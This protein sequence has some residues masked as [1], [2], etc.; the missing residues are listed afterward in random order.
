MLEMIAEPVHSNSSH[1]GNSIPG[2]MQIS[3]QEIQNRKEL[4]G[5]TKEDEQNLSE[6]RLVMVDHIDP[7]ITEY[8]DQLLLSEEV[9]QLIDDAETLQRVCE[10]M[11]RYIIDL[12]EGSYDLDYVN[13]RLR[14]GKVHH[15]IGVQPK[16]YVSAVV[17]L[18]KLLTEA[19]LKNVPSDKNAD[20]LRSALTK[21]FMFDMQ[22]VF[23]S[24]VSSL[25]AEEY[26]A[27]VELTEYSKK[28]EKSVAG[29]AEKLREVSTRDALTG[30][31]NMRG[32]SENLRRELSLA[33][34]LSEP[35]TLIYIDLNGLNKLNGKKG[36]EEGDRIL[37]QVGAAILLS[38]RD[39]D[40]ACRY[41]SDEFCIILPRTD[42]DIARI[43][44]ERVVQNF[45]KEETQGVTISAGLSQTGPENFV[46]MSK[47]VKDAI[48][49]MS[50][51]KAP[52]G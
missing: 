32:F 51:E 29:T 13:K 3:S 9:R 37:S 39:V 52:P 10:V 19:M 38:V 4:L 49:W 26:S 42:I 18:Q 31:Y 23:D 8:Y 15:S 30:L 21:L 28:L 40:Y 16:L 11:R 45:E 24:Y 17:L 36:R 25:M 1:T 20:D 2:Q 41:G 46:H 43:V 35:L 33:E 27:V 5:F 14:I 34:R 47:L 6:M 44:Y 50:K 12:F 22:L 48:H 7:T